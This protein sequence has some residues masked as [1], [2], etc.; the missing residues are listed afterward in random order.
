M[1]AEF[2]SGDS[3]ISEITFSPDATVVAIE[4]ESCGDRLILVPGTEEVICPPVG[5]T[6]V[7][8]D[9]MF[10]VSNEDT[11]GVSVWEMEPSRERCFFKTQQRMVKLAFSTTNK[12]PAF[13]CG[14]KETPSPKIHLWDVM[15]CQNVG[16]FDMEF[17][18]GFRY[19]NFSTSGVVLETNRGRIPIPHSAMEQ[20]SRTNQ[21]KICSNVFMLWT[22]GFA[23]DVS[24]CYGSRRRTGLTSAMSLM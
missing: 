11:Y 5:D 7:L 19:F 10:A 12:L 13:S 9:P 20:A 21:N 24:S 18:G 4:Y 14:N 6:F 3:S 17:L 1:I 8:S 15:S 23:R 2:E 22:N 16:L